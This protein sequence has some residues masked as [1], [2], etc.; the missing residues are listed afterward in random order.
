MDDPNKLPDYI[1]PPHHNPKIDIPI[2]MD[3]VYGY[4]SG[5]DNR[6][7]RRELERKNKKKK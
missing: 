1:F 3:A 7:K 4:A 6:R 2:V 5:Q